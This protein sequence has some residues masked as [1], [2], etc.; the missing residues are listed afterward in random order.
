LEKEFE[1]KT[2]TQKDIAAAKDQ[3]NKDMAEYHDL[4]EQLEKKCTE[5]EEEKKKI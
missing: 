4:I 5:F 2:Q 1:E 3:I